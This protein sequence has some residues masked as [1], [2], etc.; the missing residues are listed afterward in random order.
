MPDV[1]WLIED[2]FAE[3][4]KPFID[5]VEKFGF[6]YKRIKQKHYE[7]IDINDLFPGE[8]CVVF[9]GSLGLAKRIKREAR[10]IPG[11]YYDVPKYNCVNY[12][13]VLGKYL[14][15]ENYIML[16]FGEL[17][18][19]KEFLY[20]RLGMD[21][22]L[23]IRPNRGDKIFT[24]QLVLKENFDKDVEYFGF[25]TIDPFELVVV[26]EPRNIDAEWRF[27]V[28][29]MK[30]IAGSQY[31]ENERVA[32]D[33]R[34]PKEALD[35]ANEISSCYHPESTFVVDICRTKSGNYRLMEV[36]CFSCA[37]LYACN[38]EAVV[39]SVSDIAV[40]EWESYQS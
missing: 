10:W 37:G 11:V 24:G 21:R 40:K 32:V 38:R 6:E 14:L 17:T 20:D 8:S 34:Y 39:Q 33:A 23:F 12:Y 28:A 29:E 3:D 7:I 15:N 27:V 36:G 19:Q 26:S 5:A 4:T 25:H 22:A 18:R 9:Y 13:A 31:R 16:P 2:A 35:L 30:V 1:K